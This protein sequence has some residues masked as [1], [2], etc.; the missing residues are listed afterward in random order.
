MAAEK[1]SKPQS[2]PQAKHKAIQTSGKKKFAIARASLFPGKGKVTV[3]GKLLQSFTPE[4]VKQRIS[5]P[6]ILAGPVASQVDIDVVMSG[7]GFQGQGE[8][9]RLAIGKA[10]AEFD[11]KLKRVF[12]DYDR[13]LLVA[14]VRRKESRKP[15]DSKAR[16]ARQTSYR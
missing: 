7:G 5:E 13:H 15:N 10:L 1:Q 12:L 3:N 16:A 4:L 8:A 11:K 2:K 14:D 9:A 6:L